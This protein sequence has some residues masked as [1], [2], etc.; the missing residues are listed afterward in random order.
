MNNKLLILCTLLILAILITSCAP[1]QPKPP[2]P[3]P[4]PPRPT[5]TPTPTT[6]NEILIGVEYAFPG[7]ADTFAETGISTVKFYPETYAR[8]NEMQPS[9]TSEIDFSKTD[10][11]VKEYQNA[12]FTNIVI[13]VRHDSEWGSKDVGKFKATNHV[14]KPEHQDAY[15]TW[16]TSYIER[17]DHDGTNDMPGL[18]SPIRY[19]EIGV[20]F[21]S[22]EPGPVN[23]YVTFLQHTY[24]IAHE[25]YPDVIITHAAFLT[26][27]AFEDTLQATATG[28]SQLPDKHH[29]LGDMQKVLDHPEA[30]DVVNFHSLGAP[31]EIDANVAWLT[32]EMQQRKYSKPIIISDTSITPFIGW[33][34]ATDCKGLLKGIIVEPAT[35]ADRCR[36]G[37]YFTKLVNEDAETEAWTRQ[38]VAEDMTK[39]VVIAAA[40]DVELINT[41]FTEDLELFKKLFKAG[42]GNG[43][44][45]G[46]VDVQVNRATNE[47]TVTGKY[48]S[49]YAL[50]HVQEALQSYDSITRKDV[51]D[52][53]I[54]VYEVKNKGRTTWIAWIDDGKLYL[55]GDSL[56]TK[57][58]D[59]GTSKQ[60]F[61]QKLRTEENPKIIDS[62]P[63]PGNAISISTTPKFI[64]A[65]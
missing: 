54:R 65:S 24:D 41:A 28:F 6:G 29:G 40:N 30:F 48:P 42:T 59:L 9:P 14:P 38:Y 8:W 21:S 16:I 52:D 19:Y 39:R 32:K 2:R 53:T 49:F 64:R 34:P 22:Y 43:A 10:A 62:L 17:Y 56:P 35:E 27:R 18:R 12:G 20:E 26:T 5:P 7:Y 25:T 15:D 36:L 23:E 1:P 63:L 55:P 3:T 51:G 58:L 47:R 50:Q 13:G 4:G 31:E 44:W 57:I 33:G 45:G 37:G 61:V 11:I 60:V 46:M